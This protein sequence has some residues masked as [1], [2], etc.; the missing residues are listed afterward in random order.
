M[1]DRRDDGPGDAWEFDADLEQLL[2]NAPEADAEI[3]SCLT[4]GARSHRAPRRR[5]LRWP[6]RPGRVQWARWTSLLL[7][8]LAAV[9]VAMLSALGGMISYEPLRH[10]ASPSVSHTLNAWW[11]LLIYGP[12]VVASLSI[13]RASLYQ[14]QV[15]HS[16]LVVLLFSGL[17]VGLCVAQAPATVTGVAVAGLPPV[18]ALVAFHQIVRQLTVLDPPRPVMPRHAIP[19]QRGAARRRP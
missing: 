4:A 12:W 13:L 8:A 7:A 11:P 10:V 19:R 1:L 15:G 17:A 18:S 5:R 9:I 16:W 2:R 3:A 6:G 14:R